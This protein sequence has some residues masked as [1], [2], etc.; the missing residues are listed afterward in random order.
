MNDAV[1]KYLRKT[2]N[3]IFVA[4]GISLPAAEGGFC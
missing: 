1:V 4:L 3:G 2:V